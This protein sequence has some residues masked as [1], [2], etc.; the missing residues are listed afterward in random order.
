MPVL[1]L[2]IF[3]GHGR[4]AVFGQAQHDDEQWIPVFAG[5]KRNYMLQWEY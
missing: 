4:E 2:T 1:N 3:A 5:M